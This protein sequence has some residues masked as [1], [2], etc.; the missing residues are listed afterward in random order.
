LTTEVTSIQSVLN[1]SSTNSNITF[2]VATTSD[3]E[4]NNVEDNDL[5]LTSPVI[6]MRNF[7]P[8]NA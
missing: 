5:P 8:E 3:I 4:N 7:S 1:I 2:D 6:K